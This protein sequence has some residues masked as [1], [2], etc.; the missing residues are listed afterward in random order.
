MRNYIYITNTINGQTTRDLIEDYINSKDQESFFNSWS[1]AGRK[2]FSYKYG[3]DKLRNTHLSIKRLLDKYDVLHTCAHGGLKGRSVLTNAK[4]HVGQK[5]IAKFDIQ[6][7]FGSVTAAHICKAL[8]GLGFDKKSA[9]NFSKFLTVDGILPLGMHNSSF[10]GNLCLKECDEEIERYAKKNNLN[11]TRYV[12]DI[13]VSGNKMAS[14][15]HIADIVAK[16][17]FQLNYNKTRFQKRGRRQYVTG[18]SVFDLKQPRVGKKYKK[19]LRL[20][21]HLLSRVRVEQFRLSSQLMS[22]KSRCKFLNFHN[23]DSDEAYCAAYKIV[24]GKINYVHAIEPG[25]ARK[26]YT[27]FNTIDAA[28]C[29]DD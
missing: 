28:F 12:D 11:Y 20:E 25:Y 27:K 2:A 10:L 7:F 19:L 1:L 13:T 9:T 23:M 24:K 17:G 21:V 18:L 26:L 6:N 8:G 15:K 14:E 5:Y 29:N 3:D 4:P 16:Y 22:K